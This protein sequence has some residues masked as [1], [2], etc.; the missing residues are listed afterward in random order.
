MLNVTVPPILIIP[1]KFAILGGVFHF[2]QWPGLFIANPI[3]FPYYVQSAWMF[4][5]L[6]IASL[7]MLVPEI[8]RFARVLLNIL[9]KRG[10]AVWFVGV[11]FWLDFYENMCVSLN[12]CWYC[13][14]WLRH[15]KCIHVL[16]TARSY[17]SLLVILTHWA[18]WRIYASGI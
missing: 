16:N 12:G 10:G 11:S 18:E 14:L 7:V 2:W 5:V 15:S 4:H 17:I 3:Y 1:A 9:S 6:Q 8:N 13:I